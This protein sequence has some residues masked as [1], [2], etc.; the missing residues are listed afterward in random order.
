[1]SSTLKK[2]KA[3]ILAP[4]STLELNALRQTIDVVHE[5]WLETRRLNEP[6]E[7]GFRLKAD[8]F[9]VLIV[10]ADFVHEEV[11]DVA[12][13]LKLVGL[14]RGSTGHVDVEAATRHGVLVINTPSRNAQAVAELS[15]GL[16]LS[17]ARKIP[18]AHQ[19]VVDGRW[20][21]PIEPY[22]SMRGV[23]L[24]GKVVGIVGLGTIGR[25]LAAICLAVGMECLAYDP[26][27]KTVPGRIKSVGLERLLSSSDFIT[28]HAPLTPETNGLLDSSKIAMMSPGS[29]L[30]NLSDAA[31]V[32]EGALV[33]ALQSG[34]IAGAAMDVFET[35]PI[36]PSSPLKSLDNLVLTPHIGGATHETIERHSKMIGDDI[37]RFVAGQRPQRLVNPE[38]WPSE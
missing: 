29:Y 17:L 23:E 5:N 13:A 38:A 30:I 18:E 11:F 24:A 28:V 15:L 35:H 3:L 25:S 4:F 21:N 7:L 2:T 16:M 14:C 22:M 9:S 33:E 27:S 19:Y 31:I 12:P 10:E 32:V 20:S 36:V 6:S 37:R 34:R 1:M 26:Y 8:G